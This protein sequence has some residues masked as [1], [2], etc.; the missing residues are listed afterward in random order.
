MAQQPKASNRI[1]AVMAALAALAV[2]SLYLSTKDLDVAPVTP[3]TQ[4]RDTVLVESGRREAQTEV[5]APRDYVDRSEIDA[6][7]ENRLG[8]LP[9]QSAPA[10]S[11]E[12]GKQLLAQAE[13]VL[14]AHLENGVDAALAAVTN[15]HLTLPTIY[16]V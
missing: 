5:Q 9:A 10:R 6:L 15:T 11:I 16:S 12:E 1:T 3:D 8:P 4:V 2:T 14:K 7:V 13:S